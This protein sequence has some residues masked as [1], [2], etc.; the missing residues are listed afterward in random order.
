MSGLLPIGLSFNKRR[1]TQLAQKQTA[2]TC[3]C[4]SA[5]RAAQQCFC[6]LFPPILPAFC[7][8]F[9]HF[10]PHC[11]QSAG[12]HTL[13]HTVCGRRQSAARSV[14]SIQCSCAPFCAAPPSGAAAQL[15]GAKQEFTLSRLSGARKTA[16]RHSVQPRLVCFPPA[17][18][19]LPRGQ[20]AGVQLKWA[21]L[22]LALCARLPTGNSRAH[23]SPAPTSQQKVRR[24]A[25]RDELSCARSLT[26][27]QPHAA[28]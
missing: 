28:R 16:A 7:P 20:S 3:F 14:H 24:L 15:A 2:T 21:P 11:T 1:S 17:T 6:P 19:E 9:A 27:G 18:P 25:Q 12:E 22:C 26:S 5:S 23:F 4:C 10:F 8:L 13:P